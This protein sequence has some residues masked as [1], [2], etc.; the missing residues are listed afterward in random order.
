MTKFT[1]FSFFNKQKNGIF[2]SKILY[3]LFIVTSTQFR[4]A[5][6]GKIWDLRQNF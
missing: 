5:K 4:M 3:S 2:G 6:N 1:K